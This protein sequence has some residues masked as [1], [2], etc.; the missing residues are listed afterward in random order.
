MF[1]NVQFLL[2]VIFVEIESSIFIV[3]Y[4]LHVYRRII[5]LTFNGI[6]VF[7][8]EKLI[9]LKYIPMWTFLFQKRKVNNLNIF[10]GRETK[11]KPDFRKKNKRITAFFKKKK[12][13]SF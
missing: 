4:G 8:L 10:K 11:I 3:L 12:I 2:C 1:Q 9:Y 13:P 5:L 7:L 6:F